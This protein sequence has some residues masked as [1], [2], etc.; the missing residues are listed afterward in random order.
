MLAY[1]FP[2]LRIYAQAQNL[3]TLTPFSGL[4][5]EG[6]INIYAAQYPMSRQFTIGLDLTF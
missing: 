2:K 1:S 5:P 3:F 6:V 4:D